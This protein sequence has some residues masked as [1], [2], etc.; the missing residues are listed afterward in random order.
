M[1]GQ[2]KQNDAHKIWAEV[3]NN[4]QEIKKLIG[5]WNL[6]ADSTIKKSSII[7]YLKVRS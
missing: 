7:N 6:K 4:I 5:E 1:Q 2:Q 3:K